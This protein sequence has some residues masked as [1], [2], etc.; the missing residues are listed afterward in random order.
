M[1]LALHPTEER[2]LTVAMYL[3][4]FGHLARAEHVPRA[5]CPISF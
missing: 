1:N 4:E 5:R 2:M 3:E